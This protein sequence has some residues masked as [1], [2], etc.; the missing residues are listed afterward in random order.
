VR[1]DTFG[2]VQRCWPDPSP[3]DAREARRV[4]RHAARLAMGGVQA[5]S[6]VIERPGSGCGGE[7]YSSQFNHVPLATVAGKTRKMPP[8]FINGTSNVSRAFL[9]Y[10][11]PLV[12]KLPGFERL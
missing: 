6:V 12:G 9:D 8:E 4:G 7:A 1:A 3:V 11:L 5:A 10:C 2:Y